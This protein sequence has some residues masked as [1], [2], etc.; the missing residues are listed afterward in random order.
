MAFVIPLAAAVGGGSAVTGGVLLASAAASLAAGVVSYK[1][2]VRAGEIANAQSKIDANAEGDAAR[3]REMQRKRGLLRAI[4]SQ[5]AQSGAAGVAFAEGSPAAI[6]QLDIAEAT[7]D[8]NTD[9]VNVR[10]RQR[11]IRLQGR[12]AETGA[13]GQATASLIDTAANT[14]RTL[15]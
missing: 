14:A 12:N 1:Q 10:A 4:S 8:L 13:R 5:V 15:I 6:A 9:R 11:A 3:D 7:K 2:T